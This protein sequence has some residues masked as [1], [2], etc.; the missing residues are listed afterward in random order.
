MSDSLGSNGTDTLS[1]DEAI[2][3]LLESD[4][5]FSVTQAV[6]N[7]VD[8]KVYANLDEH[9]PQFLQRVCEAYAEQDFIIYEQERW[10]YGLFYQRAQQLATAMQA[11]FGIGAGDRVA[12]ALRNY[13]E[14][15]LLLMATTL[16]GA[17]CVPMNAWWTA[18]ELAFGLRDCGAK[19]VFADGPRA[20]KIQGYA[21]ANNLALVGVRDAQTPECPLTLEQMLANPYS[22]SIDFISPKADDDFLI[23][24]SSGSTGKPKGVVLTHRGT[25]SAVRSWLMGRVM[26]PLIN[27][28]SNPP[29][30]TPSAL[31]ATPLFHVTALHPNF[32]MGMEIGAKISLLYKWDVNTAIE[33]IQREHVTRFIGVPTQSAELMDAVKKRG[34]ELDSLEQVGAGGAKRPAAQVA[35]LAEVFPKA[36][37]T[38]GWGMTETNALGINIAGEDYLQAPESTGRPM[39]AVQEMKIVD[40]EGRELPLGEVGELIVKSPANMRCYLNQPEATADVLRDGWLYTGDLA[41]VDED[42]LYYIVD[43]KK[44]IIIRGG[45]NISCLEVEGALHAH[46]AVVEA[47]VFAIADERLGEVVGAAVH[48]STAIP[49]SDGELSD[50]LAQH[51]APF[52]VPEKFWFFHQ[53]LPRGATDKTDRR[54]IQAQCLNRPN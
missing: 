11:Q 36:Q 1:R 23:L 49:V 34:L 16:S 32:L 50:Y 33:L 48:I 17:V 9:M 29:P 28:A 4:P 24:Y 21:T 38:A 46:P 12:I 47:C 27:G 10:T 53:P 15:P 35:L 54:A 26:N 18:E 2:S 6:L 44:N 13:P 51:I 22:N 31:V 30:K 41:R 20:Q 40:D 45:E 42:G 43:R 5:R 52:K 14:F 39:P 19:L 37:I 25:L 7:G 3:H 8:H